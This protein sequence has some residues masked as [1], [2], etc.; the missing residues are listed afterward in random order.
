V[1]LGQ[2]LGTAS[3][4]SN[5][6]VFSPGVKLTFTERTSVPDAINYLDQGI[7]IGR[8]VYVGVTK[9]RKV[10]KYSITEDSWDTLPLA[11]VSYARIGYLNMKVL[12]VGG[13]LPSS[14]VTADIHEFD[15]ASQQWVRSTSIPPMPTARSSATAV[16][17][18]SPPALIICGGYNQGYQPTTV[19]EVYHS[20][21]SQ[22]HA[23]TP[24]PFPR[25]SMTHTVI[26][27]VLYLMGGFE[28]M[29]AIS[30]KKTVLS[31]LI[32]QLLETSLQSSPT[33]WQS[34]SI[35]NISNYRSGTASLGGCLLAVGGA[36][37][38]SWPPKPK[39]VVS[40]VHAYCPSTS[41]WV[42]VGQLPQPLYSC[43]TATLPTE[44]LLVMGGVTPSCNVINTTYRCTLSMLL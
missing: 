43:I 9:D 23:V 36:K 24:L 35:A 5:L 8:D 32:P 12:I 33:K 18:S 7:T 11:P 20:R 22:W 2:A 40:S 4:K 16:S 19:V 44:E 17:W 21:T 14:Q 13:R 41:S 26:H 31:T 15:E 6:S 25:V 39:S 1:K 27:N 28:G 3:S 10:F 37:N 30:C 29:E 42:L 34:L 38:P